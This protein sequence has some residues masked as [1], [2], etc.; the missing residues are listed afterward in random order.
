M[1]IYFL[2][3]PDRSRTTYVYPPSPDLPSS[4][5]NQSG[6]SRPVPLSRRLQQLTA[7][8]ASLETEFSDPANPLL[9]KEREE[10]NVDPGE[11]IKDLVVVRSRLDKMRKGHEGRARL[12]GTVVGDDR[13]EPED[14]A[15]DSDIEDSNNPETSKLRDLIDLDKRVEV[16][17][18]L[19]GSSNAALD[20]VILALHTGEFP[21]THSCLDFTSP[22]TPITTDNTTQLSTHTS[23]TTPAHRFF[24]APSKTSSIRF[25]QSICCTATPTSLV[26]VYFSHY[27]HP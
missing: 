3:T 15:S 2:D 27:A 7:E 21:P 10:D 18:M 17:E 14:E 20:E 6:V 25:R 23:D 22:S 11:L 12:I 16:L 19:I 1:L 9:Q 5:T 13:P 26:S 8:L 4:A 24:I